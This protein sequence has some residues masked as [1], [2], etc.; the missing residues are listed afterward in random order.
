LS[1]PL[2]QVQPLNFAK[3]VKSNYS[4]QLWNNDI[5]FYLDGVSF[6]Y[7][8]NP[9]DQARAPRGRIW[10]KPSEGL[11][12]GCTAKGAKSGTGGK[13]VKLIVAISYSKG[14]LDCEQY[15]IMNAAYFKNYVQRKFPLLFQKADKPHSK[16]WLQDG[17][18][19]Q[20]SAAARAEYESLGAMLFPIPP[21]SPDLNPIE[22]CFHTVRK[23]LERQALDNDITQETYE[24]FSRRVCH[25]I[26]NLSIQSID[27]VIDTMN[28]II[29]LI[30][31][32][33]G[34]RIRY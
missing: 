20:N 14:V 6:I 12:M 26:N 4:Q 11:E 24:E 17:D 33:Q 7:R 27:N 23:E 8:R 19:S 5:I 10:R 18:P 25:T 32:R 16:L 1:G 31:E 30:I 9:T 34:R 13:L 2:L 3:N 21:R 28:Q 22:N 29:N 15:E